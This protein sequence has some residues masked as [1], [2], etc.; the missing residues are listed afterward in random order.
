ML[1]SSL[2]VAIRHFYNF[3]GGLPTTV[4]TG[5]FSIYIQVEQAL[6]SEFQCPWVNMF[7]LSFHIS[8][9][10]SDL[11]ISVAS[12]TNLITSH[13]LTYLSS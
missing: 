9:P 13:V 8:T 11:K 7:F 1:R 3:Q 2:D 6:I 10:V 12:S 5:K 4:I